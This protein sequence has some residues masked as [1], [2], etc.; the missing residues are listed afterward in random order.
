MQPSIAWPCWSVLLGR[1]RR[2]VAVQRQQFVGAP[3]IFQT[4]KF[5][6]PLVS[7]HQTSWNGFS[8]SF[9]SRYVVRWK[10]LHKGHSRMLRR[11]AMTIS[12][13]GEKA[14]GIGHCTDPMWCIRYTWSWYIVEHSTVPSMSS[15]CRERIDSST[16]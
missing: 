2:F 14:C 13:L 5:R 10:R 6:P 8:G 7:V 15:R 4:A 3:Y 9:E 11:R 1:S 16:K 12:E